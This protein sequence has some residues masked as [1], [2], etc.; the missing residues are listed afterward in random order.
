[1]VFKFKKTR[2]ISGGD[3]VLVFRRIYKTP[4]H[5]FLKNTFN[6]YIYM[7]IYSFASAWALKRYESGP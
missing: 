1:M 2:D 4:L 5:I 6:V 7:Y 3:R